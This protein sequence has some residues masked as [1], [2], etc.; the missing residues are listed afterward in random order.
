MHLLASTTGIISD[1]EEAIDLSQT[2]GDIVILS[3]ADSDLAWFIGC[4]K[5]ND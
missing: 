4:T 1:G 3:A 5:P 2:P